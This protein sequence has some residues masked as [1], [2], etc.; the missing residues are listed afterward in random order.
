MRYHAAA[1]IGVERHRTGIY[2]V[3]YYHDP[4]LLALTA[5]VPA[6]WT[7]KARKAERSGLV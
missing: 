1:H 5:R 6:A 2:A 7:S 3:S 4:M